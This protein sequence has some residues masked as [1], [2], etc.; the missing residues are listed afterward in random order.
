VDKFP[1]NTHGFAQ[2]LVVLTVAFLVGAIGIGV[3]VTQENQYL[4]SN[5]KYNV[6]KSSKTKE[7]SETSPLEVALVEKTETPSMYSNLKDAFISLFGGT[8]KLG[9]L[10]PKSMTREQKPSPTLTTKA[11]RGIE[12]ESGS[13]AM[14]VNVWGSSSVIFK[15]L[16]SQAETTCPIGFWP[17]YDIVGADDGVYVFDAISYVYYHVGLDCSVTA[18]SGDPSGGLSTPNDLFWSPDYF[19]AAGDK[20][21]A[22]SSFYW[23]QHFNPS[24]NTSIGQFDEDHINAMLPIRAVY[25]RTEGSTAVTYLASEQ[26]GFIKRYDNYTGVPVAEQLLITY[27]I[28]DTGSGLIVSGYGEIYKLDYALSSVYQTLTIPN[29]SSS[30]IIKVTLNPSKTLGYIYYSDGSNTH[31]EEIDPTTFTRTG[32]YTLPNMVSGDAN[33]NVTDDAVYINGYDLVY[34][35]PTNNFDS[36]TI[37]WSGQSLSNTALVSGTPLPPNTPTPTLTP[38]PTS[39]PTPSPSPTPLPTAIPT[40]TPTPIPTSSPTPTLTPTPIPTNTP[41]PLPT[42]TPTPIPTSIPTP[43]PI[44]YSPADFDLDGDVDTADY[45]LFLGYFAGPYNSVADFYPALPDGQITVE[46]YQWF[47]Y[48]Y[49]QVNP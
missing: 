48:Y 36:H 6:P 37:Y 23:I 33:L 17:G 32:L 42:A 8:L 16:T 31:V 2:L 41:T 4:A 24:T 49:Y 11:Q 40:S 20:Q 38:I 22:T 5:A 46:D 30:H 9:K 7:V 12:S 47:L 18:F 3:I 43:T 25:V 26:G 35:I 45:N 10:E 34:R 21:A 28:A 14:V 13:L 15:D 1:E 29:A 27:D 44:V 19:V 39:T